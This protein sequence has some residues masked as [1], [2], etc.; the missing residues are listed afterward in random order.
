MVSGNALWTEHG[1]RF[2]WWVMLAEKTGHVD[3]EVRE[4]Q[5]GRVWWVSP[6]EY[7]TSRQ[8]KM[9]ATR[10]QMIQQLAEA[11]AR[12]RDQPRSEAQY[13]VCS[14]LD[15]PIAGRLTGLSQF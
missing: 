13:P 9:M 10:P 1:M 5:S 14:D 11:I 3:F 2:A 7:L 8:A 6:H 4:P 12:C 15:T